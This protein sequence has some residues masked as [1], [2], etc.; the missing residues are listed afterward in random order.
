MSVFIITWQVIEKPM[1]LGTI[2]TK[3]EGSEYSNVREIY[4]DVRLVFKNAMRYNEEKDDV[5]VMAES[6]LEKFEEKWLTIMPRLVEEV[7][8][9]T[10]VFSLFCSLCNVE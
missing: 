8:T 1:D 10:F 4:A 7:P 9:K 6:L 5:Y 3:M 2:R